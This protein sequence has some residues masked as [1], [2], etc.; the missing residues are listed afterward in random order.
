MKCGMPSGNPI[1]I[2]PETCSSVLKLVKKKK[3]ERDQDFLN[4]DRITYIYASVNSG[5]AHSATPFGQ[6]RGICGHCQSPGSGSSLPQGYPRAFDT[7][8]VYDSKYKRGGV[9]RKR[10]LLIKPQLELSLSI[11]CGVIGKDQREYAQVCDDIPG[12]GHLPSFFVPFPGY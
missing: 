9:C 12:V 2:K 4:T 8:V 7:L 5:C 10:S 11:H 6:L 1:I 3:K